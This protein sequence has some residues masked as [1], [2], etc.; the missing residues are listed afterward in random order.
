M[1]NFYIKS[2]SANG[3]GKQTSTVEFGPGLNIIHGESNTGKTCIANSI[4][5]AFGGDVQSELFDPVRTGYTEIRMAL[6]YKQKFN[7]SF[8]RVFGESKVI[9][10]SEF[11]S[12]A[13]GEYKLAYDNKHPES[14]ILNDLILRMVGFEETPMIGIK[15]SSEKQRLSWRTFFNALYLDKNRVDN[16]A[17][18]I[19]EDNTY[20]DFPLLSAMLYFLNG[21]DH[22]EN[23]EKLG[24]RVLKARNEA[25]DQ[26][27]SKQ[28]DRLQPRLE[29]LGNLLKQYHTKNEF[30]NG[31]EDVIAS[32]NVTNKHMSHAEKKLSAIFREL[33]SI[34]E[35]MSQ[36]DV[37]L[38]RYE[39]LR[40]QYLSDIERLNFIVQGE[41]ILFHEP[42]SEYCPFCGNV[43]QAQQ[44][45]SYVEASKAELK[46]T[47]KHLEGLQT[48]ENDIFAVRETH[49]VSRARLVEKRNEINEYVLEILKPKSAEL[50]DM[51]VAYHEYQK[52]KNEFD[53]LNMIVQGLPME[54]KKYQLIDNK[55]SKDYKPRDHF[56]ENFNEI[57]DEYVTDILRRCGYPIKKEAHFNI[58]TFN[59]EVDG[60]AK[61]NNQGQ[62][63]CSL[64]NTVLLLAFRKYFYTHAVYKPNLLIIDTPL[65]GLEEWKS[66]QRI[67]GALF[68]YCT[69]T[70]EEG[71]LIV[72]DNHFPLPDL[73]YNRAGTRVIS[74]TKGKM[75]GRYGFLED[76]KN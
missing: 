11:P 12:I 10:D 62:G 53:Y 63:Y 61:E 8:T 4:Y 67:S 46:K 31:I 64:F 5:F 38:S 48:A 22:S 14:L 29:E 33:I 26:F 68:K 59:I 43:L 57:I 66:K 27:V 65:L 76:F 75:P 42:K 39:T 47:I 58:K 2:I 16:S 9:V 17:S 71:Q 6:N 51:I 1:S 37:L 30:I 44:H 60:Y 72:L 20:K 74:F 54:I 40:G 24:R 73:D 18:P 13:S 52:I 56:S 36:S 7:I 3:I 19:L 35:K 45:E 32:L 69:E 50:R 21:V 70:N 15:A 34:D 55:D 28:A 25:L 49:K 41:D 23:I